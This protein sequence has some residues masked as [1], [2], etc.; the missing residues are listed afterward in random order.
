MQTIKTFLAALAAAVSFSAGAAGTFTDLWS[1]PLEPGW[2][3]SV[4]Q[5]G[6]TAFATLFV[7][8]RDG[9]PRW[10]F[11]PA[12]RVVAGEADRLPT[13][14][15]D[16]YR[17]SGP[18]FGGTFDPA[19]VAVAPVGHL[20]LYAQA[21]GRLAVLYDVDNVVANKVVSRLTWSAA[22]FAGLYDGSFRLQVTTQ[23]GTAVG[24]LLYQGDMELRVSSGMGVLTVVDSFQRTCVYRGEF[25]PSGS[26]ASM[27]GTYQCT[28][29]QEPSPQGTFEITGLEATTHGLTGALRTASPA[30]IQSGRLGGPRYAR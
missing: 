16:L 18:W 8:D 17:A 24:T 12:A 22:D 20:Q 13:F 6:D 21:D 11:A 3:M 7:Y 9:T 15:G 19:K 25:R 2:G 10:Y 1:D 28:N 26:T 29:T 27:S 30:V 4:V 5:Q 23:E 14:L